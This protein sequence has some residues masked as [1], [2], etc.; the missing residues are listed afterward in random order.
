MLYASDE[1]LSSISRISNILKVYY[2]EFKCKKKKER[3]S[4][5]PPHTLSGHESPRKVQE[6]ISRNKELGFI[7]AVVTFNT[8]AAL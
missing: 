4:V 7:F 6:E 5:V 2:I 3:K 8:G 1:S